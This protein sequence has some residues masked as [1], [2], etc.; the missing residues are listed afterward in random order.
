MITVLEEGTCKC[1]REPFGVGGLEGYLREDNYRY[2]LC[3][4]DKGKYY[5]VFP[6]EGYPDYYETC[7]KIIFGKHFEIIDRVIT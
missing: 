2:Q 3:E 5:R 7:G 4:N 1:I 6:S